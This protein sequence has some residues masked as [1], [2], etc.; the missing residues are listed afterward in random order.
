MYQGTAVEKFLRFCF[1]SRTKSLAACEMTD[2]RDVVDDDLDLV[3]FEE[4]M[5]EASGLVVLLMLEFMMKA[6]S[7]MDVL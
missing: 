3:E 5:R 4:T 1:D 6:G 7:M 2:R